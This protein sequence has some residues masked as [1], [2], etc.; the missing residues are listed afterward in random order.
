[1]DK[2]CR[3]VIAEPIAFHERREHFGETDRTVGLKTAA[4]VRHG[5]APLICIGETLS[6]REAGEADQVLKRQ[7][8]G[9]LALLEGAAKKATDAPT[10]RSP[11]YSP[12]A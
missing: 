10:I 12:T 1:M 2:P 8:E 5:L 4:A 9:A 7:V 6:E 3:I 11:S